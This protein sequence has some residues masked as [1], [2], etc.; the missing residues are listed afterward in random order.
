MEDIMKAAE[1]ER[2]GVARECAAGAQSGNKIARRAGAGGAVAA[3]NSAATAAGSSSDE[4]AGS[5][6]AEAASSAMATSGWSF[7]P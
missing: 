5:A 6:D 2:V 7:L 3:V 1:A 4:V